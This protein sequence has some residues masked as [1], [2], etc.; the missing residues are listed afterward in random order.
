M[1]VKTRNGSFANQGY[2]GGTFNGNTA[3]GGLGKAQEEK[4]MRQ[5]QYRDISNLNA[6]Y[7]NMSL[8][9]LGSLSGGPFGAVTLAD[10]PD[11]ESDYPWREES[12][13]TRVLQRELNTKLTADGFGPILEDGVLGPRTCGALK[14][15]NALEMVDGACDGHAAEFIPPQQAVPMPTTMPNQPEE[16]VTKAGMGSGWL[17]GVLLAGGAI[18]LVL[19]MQ[20]K[21]GKTVKLTSWG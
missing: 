16:E 20:K 10:L 19:Y 5:H 14:Q 13:P 17:W 12:E 2:G 3:F 15:Y 9:G 11:E 21:K 1:I 7:D 4:Q 8:Q 6:P 18:G